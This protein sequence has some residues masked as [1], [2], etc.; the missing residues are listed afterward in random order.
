M[1]FKPF[2]IQLRLLLAVATL[3]VSTLIIGSAS[4]YWLSKTNNILEELHNTTLNEVN[5]SH[6]LTKQSAMFTAS[7]PYLL[8]LRSSY[9]VQSE[10]NKLLGSIDETID[11]WQSHHTE[12]KNREYDSTSIL[13]TLTDM[14]E[15]IALF[16]RKS[17][18]L[19][20]HDDSTRIHTAKLVLL[21]KRLEEALLRELPEGQVNATRQAQLAV[22]KLVTA[23]NVDSLLSLGEYQ[24]AFLNLSIT[25]NYYD[26]PVVVRDVISEAHSLA[27]GP[28][29]LFET[30]FKS[31]QYSVSAHGLLGNI[32]G[33]A[34]ELNTQVLSLIESSELE[35]AKRRDETTENIKFA[36]IL[37]A[38]FGI[39]SI[40]LSLVSAFY[41]SG[42]VI[43]RLK[44]ITTT[45]TGLA[46]GNL[47]IGTAESGDR[48]DELGALQRA[49]NV[50]HSNA[51]EHNKIHSELIQKTALFEST[52]NNINDGVAITNTN[53]QLLA[54]NP[55]LNQ[56]LS[57]FGSKSEA[58]IGS[59]LSNRVT[60][61]YGELHE[62]NQSTDNRAY[63]E[64][65][66]S[67]GHVLEIR[68]S[69]LPDGG[70][71][72]L[73]SDT[74]ER[75][76][77]EER[78]QHF[79]RLE[80]LGQ[81]TGEVAH[82]V[83][84][85]LSAVKATLPS[86]LSK[87]ENKSEHSKA[88][89]RIE[90]AVDMGNSLTHRLLAF[91]KKQRLNPKYVELNDLVNGVSELISLSL[92]DGIKLTIVNSVEPLTTYI[93]PLQLESSLLNLCMNSAHA[94]ESVGEIRIT[95]DQ[96]KDSVLQIHVEDDGCG[97][98]K[99]T[100]KRAVEP[101]FSTRRG[102]NGT[103]LG[104]SIVY[105][106]VKQSGGDMQIESFVGRGTTVTLK[107]QPSTERMI[108]DTIE[109]NNKSV[110]KKTV[111]VVEDDANTL[112]RAVEIFKIAGYEVSPASSYHEARGLLLGGSQ[113][114]LLFT[115][116]HLGIGRTGWDLAKIGL[117]KNLVEA[118]VVTSG[119]I[120]ALSFPPTD[121]KTKCKT[122]K[123][124]YDSQQVLNAV[125][126]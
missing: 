120:S 42:Y 18:D 20:S 80:S 88:V 53:G 67:L 118:V 30:R 83:N 33:K 82:D 119:R 87:R 60:A 102:S 31:L 23:S 81:I 99:E 73:F 55:K 111:L 32:S 96:S 10:G 34:N 14:R 45:M 50:F 90:D 27:V 11:S 5:R 86:I 49:F 64:I 85:I 39:G 114:S 101:F 40:I 54:F 16:I 41:I 93:D 92:G 61:V 72:W 21:D 44:K 9:L 124:P 59:I 76:R 57:H 4:W 97:M 56:L 24:R 65:R 100:I 2:S 58:K 123:K 110:N 17:K 37:V 125:P 43:K 71:V 89:E 106:F 108:V 115:D 126:L 29:G 117:N 98:D 122:L 77:V 78:L 6:E 1:L 116:L 28:G 47:D 74:T 15:L 68:T 66:D 22:Q 70:S 38:L 13:A 104:L 48:N 113:F 36:K 107:F 26:S 69:G 105:G 75:R 51:V 52:F 91:A 109:S 19:S 62:T 35:I 7:A 3:S 103:G 121:L 46:E 79:Q 63:K 112:Q 8:N 84:N 25:S 95:I 94:I 12:L